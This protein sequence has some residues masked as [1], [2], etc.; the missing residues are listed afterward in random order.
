MYGRTRGR[1]TCPHDSVVEVWELQNSTQ[2]PFRDLKSMP[3]QENIRGLGACIQ[4]LA[5][6]SVCSFNIGCTQGVNVSWS[7][8]QH[9]SSAQ[10]YTSISRV[11]QW[12]EPIELSPSHPCAIYA[13]AEVAVGMSCISALSIRDAYPGTC[14]CFGFIIKESRCNRLKTGDVSVLVIDADQKIS[15]ANC[16]RKK[17]SITSIYFVGSSRTSIINMA[18]AS[19]NQPAYAKDER[20]LCFHHE[21]LYEAKVM[22]SKPKD[23]NDRKDG[24]TY[25]IHY[26]GWKNTWDDWVPQERLRKFT[27]ENKELATNLKKEMDSQRRATAPT[28]ARNPTMSKRRQLGSD[29]AGSSA[30]G[31]E[32]RSSAA[33]P[34]PPAHARGTKRGRELEGIDKED[35]FT[36]RPAVRLFVPDQLKSI[37][38]DDWEKVTKEHKLAPVPSKVP[39]SQFLEEYATA[40]S[41]NRRPGSADADILEECIAGV[42]EYFNKALGRILLYR[43]ERHQYQE[44]HKLISLGH[45]DFAGKDLVEVYGCEHLLRLFGTMSHAPS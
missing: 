35:E 13:A 29:F 14:G 40:E 17:E 12:L 6:T 2:D 15:S 1:E 7:G 31:S 25:R 18:P 22:D 16:P 36:R 4:Q 19:A 8:W 32:D 24:H 28:G 34:P 3:M 26:K 20:V 5:S 42:K 30:R 21:L 23:P 10:T 9:V 44:M 38:V 41:A 27:D 45:G 39:A 37:L 11:I 33:P 43:F